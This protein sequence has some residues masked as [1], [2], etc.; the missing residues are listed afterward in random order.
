MMR[1]EPQFKL[2]ECS[3]EKLVILPEPEYRHFCTKMLA[4]YDFIAENREFMYAEGPAGRERY[5]CLLVMGEDSED[6]VLVESGG[7]DYA[8]YVAYQPNI[9]KLSSGTNA[10]GCR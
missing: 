5:Y 1:K 2:H 7:A 10:Y 9:K 6:G 4:D 3:I 8:R